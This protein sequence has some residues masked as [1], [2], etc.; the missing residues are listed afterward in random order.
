MQR[1]ATPLPPRG[2]ILRAQALV[3]LGRSGEAYGL[4]GA[5][6]Q[7]QAWPDERLVELEAQ[8]GAASLREAGD[9]NVLADRWEALPK[10]LRSD[11]AAVAAYAERAAALRWDEAAAKSIEQALDAR[12]DES[13]AGLY[14]RLPI[15]RLDARREQR[16]ALAAGASGQSGAAAGAGAPGAR[17]GAVVAGR[18]VPAPRAR[19]GRRQRSLGRTRARFHPGRRR[20]ARA[21][22]LRQRIECRARR[23][24]RRNCPAATC[25][26]RSSTRPWSRNATSTACRDCAAEAVVWSQL[27]GDG[28]RASAPMLWPAL[29]RVLSRLPQGR[30]QLA[31]AKRQR[32]R[33]ATT[34][35]PPAVQIDTRQ[36]PPPRCFSSLA[37]VA[38]MRAPVAANGMAGRQRGTVRVDLGQVDAAHRR[39]QAEAVLAVLLALPRAQRAQHLRGEGF[40]DLV[41]VEVLQGQA[42]ALEHLRHGHGRRH[43]Q[44]FA[45]DEVDRR[46]VRVAQVAQHFVAVRARPLVR[47]Q[48]AGGGAVGQRRR[49]GGGQR[50]AAGGLVERRLQRRQLLQRCCRRAG[51]CRARRRGNSRPGRRRNRARR[52]RRAS[53]ASDSAQ[54]V[55]RI[56]RDVPL[57]G[58]VLAVVAHRL[59]GARLGHAGELGLEFA[60]VEALERGQ[61]VAR[62]LGA[63]A[64][65]SRRRRSFLP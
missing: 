11:P 41:E 22:V 33:I 46:D 54:L 56:A 16:R 26:R 7:Q 17:A 53:G 35:M 43:Q 55:L 24:D 42:V 23:S 65:S 14:G 58:H 64:A 48:Q 13:L 62:R 12:W 27:A 25:A 5:L 4:L 1:A 52:P 47:G 15:G 21:P 45:V 20:E 44:A 28:R 50:A 59:A 39:V 36:R 63:I 9:A 32:S 6:R 61:L 2:L 37:A 60:E 10:P 51:C 8:W 38:T 57:L 31:P 18:G 49:V 19:A 3:A 34:P 30:Q 40:V 29:C